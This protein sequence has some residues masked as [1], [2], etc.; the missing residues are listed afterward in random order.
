MVAVS[1]YN[2]AKCLFFHVVFFLGGGRALRLK[3]PLL[4]KM[5]HTPGSLF[6]FRHT[7]FLSAESNVETES[8]PPPL[9]F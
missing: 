7:M 6:L 8:P 4:F 3:R 2:G 1:P 5:E 9:H